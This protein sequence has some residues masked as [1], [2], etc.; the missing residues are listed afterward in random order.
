MNEGRLKQLSII[1]YVI[2]IGLGINCLIFDIKVFSVILKP[3]NDIFFFIFP[4]LITYVTYT[5]LEIY[6]FYVIVFVFL[7]KTRNILSEH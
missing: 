3:P 4:V 5:A 6:V 2:I 7:F 1:I